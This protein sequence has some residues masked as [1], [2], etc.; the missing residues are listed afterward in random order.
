MIDPTGYVL[1][2][3]RGDA[4][5]AAITTRIRAAKPRP[6]IVAPDGTVTDE[7]DARGPGQYNRYVVL[8]RLG[9]ARMRRRPVQEVRY[10]ARCYGVDERD[11]EILA[12]A[13][14]DSVQPNREQPR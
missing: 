5:V 8:A 9:A 11:S 7:G 4:T 1:T 6:R 10:V 13:V 3:I 2:T 12:N 14:S